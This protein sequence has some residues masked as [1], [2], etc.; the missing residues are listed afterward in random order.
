MV[1][2]GVLEKEQGRVEEARAWFENAKQSD[3]P[4]VSATARRERDTLD[5]YVEEQRRAHHFGKYGCQAYADSRLMTDSTGQPQPNDPPDPTATA[6]GTDNPA[7]MKE[8]LAND[9]DVGTITIWNH[10]GPR[11][12]RPPEK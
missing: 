6:A 1:N 9:D 11:E 5:R 3:H 4:K 8:H 7:D 12:R 2:L 10:S